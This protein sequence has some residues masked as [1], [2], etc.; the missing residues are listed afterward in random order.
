[1]KNYIIILLIIPLFSYG[2]V[3]IFTSNPE[4]V[5]HIAGNSPNVI[6]EGLSETNNLKNLGSESTTRVFVDSEGDLVLG[7]K[8]NNIN[9]LFDTNNYI[10]DNLEIQTPQTGTGSNFT[11]LFLPSHTWE[12][13]TMLQDGFVEINYSLSWYIGKNPVFKISDGGARAVE[14][15]IFIWD[16]SLPNNDTDRYIPGNFAQSGQ[17]YSNGDKN[18]GADGKGMDARFYNTGS[19]Y[20]PLAAG[21]YS[22][23]LGVRLTEI[24]NSNIILFSGGA[25]DQLQVIAYY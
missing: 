22:V 5:L 20:I 23:I 15:T 7:N 21:T 3:G 6:I 17:F 13:F 25:N 4:E 19:D 2:Q 1:M 10:P 11:K 8:D 16:H 12:T 14:S 24:G 9:F 18:I